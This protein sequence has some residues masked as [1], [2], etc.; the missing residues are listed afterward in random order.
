MNANKATSGKNQE[1]EE[2]G[3]K[4]S[5]WAQ[6]KAEMALFKD[7]KYLPQEDISFSVLIILISMVTSTAFTIV[8]HS[9]LT[10]V[11]S[12]FVAIAHF[13]ASI[14]FVTS[15]IY[16]AIQ[17]MYYFHEAHSVHETLFPNCG[18]C[19]KQILTKVKS[20]LQAK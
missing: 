13:F 15:Y 6:L 20:F 9:N 5:R 3:V 12:T 16:L 10:V 2:K 14:V 8:F 1:E 18:L 4:L 17:D 7:M 19:D 11:S